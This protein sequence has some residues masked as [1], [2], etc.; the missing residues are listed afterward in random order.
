MLFALW[1]DRLIYTPRFVSSIN[2]TDLSIYLSIPAYSFL[3]VCVYSYQSIYL[4]IYLEL[5]IYSYISK[6]GNLSQ[7]RPEGSLFNSYH[8]EV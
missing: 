3:H 5:H 6:V 7:E 2:S 8:I 4:S 1:H